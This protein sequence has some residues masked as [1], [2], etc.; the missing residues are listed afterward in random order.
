LLLGRIMQPVVMTVLFVVVFIPIGLILRLFRQD[1]MRVFRDPSRDSYWQLRTPP[2]PP[3]ET[4][5]NQF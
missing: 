3:P 4:L 2:G 5:V 1:P